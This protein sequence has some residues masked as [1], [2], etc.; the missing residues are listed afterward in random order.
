MCHCVS[1]LIAA[2]HFIIPQAG[3]K[4]LHGEIVDLLCRTPACRDNTEANKD[5]LIY[6]DPLGESKCS[7]KPRRRD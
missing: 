6:A 2:A 1:V 4:E 5:L 3:F 7:E